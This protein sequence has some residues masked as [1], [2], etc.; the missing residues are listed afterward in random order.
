MVL[1][2]WSTLKRF[3]R[4]LFDYVFGVRNFEDTKSMRVIFFFNSSKVIPVLEN[5][6][7]DREK[8]FYFWDNCISIC[9][10]KFSL[11]GTG[12]LSLLANLLT[13]SPK[14]WHIN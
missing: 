8:F 13:G 3:F 14:I 5:L 6:A 2:E 10:V 12:Y 1:F 4:H 9:I 11:L 7:K